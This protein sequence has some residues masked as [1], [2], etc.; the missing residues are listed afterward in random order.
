MFHIAGRTRLPFFVYPSPFPGTLHFL[1]NPLSVLFLL[2][3]TIQKCCY[4][5]I[6]LKVTRQL[7]RVYWSKLSDCPFARV[8]M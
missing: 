8:V 7:L 3:A 6:S 1:F 2:T 5:T 4:N